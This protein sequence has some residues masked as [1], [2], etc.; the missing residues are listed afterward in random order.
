MGEDSKPGFAALARQ[1]EDY[2]AATS[3]IGHRLKDLQIGGAVKAVQ[4]LT[5]SI[6]GLQVSQ[7][8]TGF[9]EQ[10]AKA[11]AQIQSQS[12]QSAIGQLGTGFLVEIETGKSGLLGIAERLQE[13][14]SR[15][16]GLSSIL[17]PALANLQRDM[18]NFAEALLASQQRIEADAPVSRAAEYGVLDYLRGLPTPTLSKII[19][20][21]FLYVIP[22]TLALDAKR[23]SWE[24]EKRQK[25][26]LINDE[27]AKAQ[28]EEMDQKLDSLTKIVEFQSLILEEIA[29]RD[30]LDEGQER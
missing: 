29:R 5:S 14:N 9:V 24:S 25:M 6:A 30:C 22:N 20:F 27:Q 19:L 28:H 23:D 13:T 17:G 3:L 1:L 10:L 2:Q 21:L 12:F 16:E 26:S 18:P 4:P 7:S 8:Y 11:T 15:F